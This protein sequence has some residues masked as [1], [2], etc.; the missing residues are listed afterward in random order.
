MNG[1]HAPQMSGNAPNA[2]L[3]TGIKKKNNE[4]DMDDLIGQRF[5]RLLVLGIKKK[6]YHYQCLCDCGVKK[7]IRKYELLNGDTKSC[8][9]LFKETLINRNTTHGMYGIPEHN[10][11]IKM[12]DRC[13]NS[14]NKDFKHYG[15]R[16]IIVCNRWNKFKNFFKDMGVRPKGLTLERIDNNGNYEPSN[17]KWATRAEQSQNTRHTR[18]FTYNGTTKC[19]SDWARVCG[20]HQST[21]HRRLAKY[22][23]SKALNM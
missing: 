15:N 14:K 22:T 13:N 2:N 21:M 23:V 3:I 10:V 11:W 17:C 19:I 4:M 18:M 12:K 20:V 5:G 6:K 16:G 9:C 7:E 8:G 1:I